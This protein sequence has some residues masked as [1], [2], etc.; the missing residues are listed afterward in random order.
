MK[1]NI[2]ICL[3]K[4]E[5]KEQ[6]KSSRIIVFA[7][8]FM[9]FGFLSPI[10]AKYTP[11]IIESI[12]ESQNISISIPDPTWYDAIAQ[13]LKNLTQMGAFVLILVYM[14][15]I[16][17]EKESGTVLF[18]LV[19]PVTRSSFIIA[20]FASVSIAAIISM[21][22]SFIAASLYT[23]LFF[24][25]FNIQAFAILNVFMLLY[26]FAVLFLTLLF[27]TIFKSQ[28]ISGIMSFALFLLISLFG[29]LESIS[30]YLPSAMITESN[31]VIMGEPIATIPFVSIAVFLS[32]CLVIS[33][34]VFNKWEP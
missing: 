34:R 3:L 10:G 1:F 27:S 4:K 17:R 14:G 29:Q 20:K 31:N 12:S 30:Q 28:I 8:V 33:L 24:D 23:Y 32:L 21:I 15:L 5:I 6:F 19:K 7:A 11:Q 16:S 13:Y 9:F 18:L 26:V 25:G 2:F 22:I